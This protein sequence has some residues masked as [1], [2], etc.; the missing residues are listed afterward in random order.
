MLGEPP[1]LLLLK[2]ISDA[3]PTSD[4]VRI[5]VR[6][7]TISAASVRIRAETAGYEAAATI[8]QSLRENPRFKGARKGDE[9]KLGDGISFSITIPLG[10]E[11]EEEG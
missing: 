7:L 10:E 2:E 6:E 11:S 3:M 1:T 8:E 9:K 4:E 5:E